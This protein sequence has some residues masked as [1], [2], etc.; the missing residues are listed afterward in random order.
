MLLSMFLMQMKKMEEK[1]DKVN[2]VYQ[3]SREMSLAMGSL[4]Y[5]VYCCH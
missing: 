5:S 2:T 4:K 3:G 1:R